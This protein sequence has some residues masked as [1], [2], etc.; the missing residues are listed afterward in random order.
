VVVLGNTINIILGGGGGLTLAVCGFAILVYFANTGWDSYMFSLF[1]RTKSTRAELMDMR[2]PH[3]TV[4]KQSQQQ[5]A[6]EPCAMCSHQ[7][8]LTRSLSRNPVTNALLTRSL[9]RMRQV[10]WT[11]H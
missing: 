9:S 7:A 5:I 4:A 8:L 1:C 10:A 11:S 3:M 2:Q 6:Q